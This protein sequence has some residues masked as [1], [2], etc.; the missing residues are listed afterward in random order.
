MV[1]ATTYMIS[2]YMILVLLTSLLL[3]WA[4]RVGN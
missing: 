1:L 2:A 3:F 4:S